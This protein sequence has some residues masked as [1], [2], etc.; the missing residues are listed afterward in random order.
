MCLPIRSNGPIVLQSNVDRTRFQQEVR[1]ALADNR[2]TRQ[3]FTSLAQKFNHDFTDTSYGQGVLSRL[4]TETQTINT[5]IDTAFSRNSSGITVNPQL[6]NALMG[7]KKESP[8]TNEVFANG[9]ENVRDKW[10]EKFDTPFDQ[11]NVIYTAPDPNNPQNKVSITHAQLEAAR[12]N[13]D[14]DTVNRF[15]ASNVEVQFTGGK[16]RASNN[17]TEGSLGRTRTGAE[18]VVDKQNLGGFVCDHNAHINNALLASGARNL[19][20]AGFIHIPENPVPEQ[21]YDVLG[22]GIKGNVES[23]QNTVPANQP[24]RIMLTSFTQFDYVQ[25]NATSRYLIGNGT[26]NNFGIRRPSAEVQRNLNAMMQDKLG[27]RFVGVQDNRIVYQIPGQNGNPAR[28]VELSLV[29]LPVDNDTTSTNAPGNPRGDGTQRLLT[30]TFRAVNPNAII[31]LGVGQYEN[32]DRY[33]IE[34][35]SEGLTDMTP[36]STPPTYPGNPPGKLENSGLA[37][38]YRTQMKP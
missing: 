28:R 36:G 5:D 29:R 11:N 17:G 31:S 35:Q 8:Y 13:N 7:L 21:F 25:D 14:T 22:T 26:G 12:T 38:I 2:L 15:T 18:V 10:N 37:D 23:L 34:T 1:E 3:E 4:L 32:P 9:S 19:T 6:R 27:A 20:S 30:D 33:I 16:P 24:I